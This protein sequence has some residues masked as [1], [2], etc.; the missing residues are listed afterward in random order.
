MSNM[1]NKLTDEELN[2]AVGG[3]SIDSLD[4]DCISLLDAVRGTVSETSY[5]TICRQVE[6][7]G[8]RDEAYSLIREFYTGFCQPSTGIHVKG[9]KKPPAKKK[10]TKSKKK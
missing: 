5:N 9:F 10:T 2:T 3:M 6:A 7:C 4:G 1:I 8:S